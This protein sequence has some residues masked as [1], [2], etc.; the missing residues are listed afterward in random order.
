MACLDILIPSP[1]NLYIITQKF[2]LCH[3]KNL[4]KYP[5]IPQYFSFGSLEI[6][7]FFM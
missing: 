4:S 7:E 2:L 6:I 5:D 1:I 3:W